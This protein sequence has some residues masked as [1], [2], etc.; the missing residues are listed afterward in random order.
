MDTE[1]KFPTTHSIEVERAKDALMELATEAKPLLQA[2]LKGSVIVCGNATNQL[3]YALADMDEDGKIHSGVMRYVS[4]KEFKNQIKGCPLLEEATLHL[5]GGGHRRSGPARRVIFAKSNLAAQNNAT[6]TEQAI[7]EF[8]VVVRN[9]AEI[10]NRPPSG[11]ATE[12]DAQ[13]LLPHNFCDLE[14]LEIF[15]YINAD[16][17]TTTAIKVGRSTAITDIKV[18]AQKNLI[19]VATYNFTGKKVRLKKN[20][21]VVKIK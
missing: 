3:N 6:R 18:D 4:N 10:E 17:K 16:D 14:L 5:D 12:H 8:T 9:G 20:T 7:A 11:K 21:M 1:F 15:K 2:L 19:N 13:P